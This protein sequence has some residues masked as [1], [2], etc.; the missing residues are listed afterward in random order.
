MPKEDNGKTKQTLQ[1]AMVETYFQP[2]D[3]PLHGSLRFLYATLGS[4]SL[5]VFWI[6]RDPDPPAGLLL[7]AF[8]IAVIRYT[9]M[10]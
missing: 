10:I 5:L 9:F 6:S 2:L 7:P 3:K 4:F 8:V 1:E